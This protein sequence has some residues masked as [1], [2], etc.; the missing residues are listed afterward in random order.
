MAPQY[1]LVRGRDAVGVDLVP[2][3]SATH[4]DGNSENRSMPG[5]GVDDEV[6]AIREK[7]DQSSKDCWWALVWVRSSTGHRGQSP[8]GGVGTKSMGRIISQARPDVQA[9]WARARV[10]A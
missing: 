3:G 1:R 10:P 9:L 8:L 5:K 7:R 2:D 6:S 4:V